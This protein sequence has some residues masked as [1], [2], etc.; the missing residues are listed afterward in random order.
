[1][2][3]AEERRR[4]LVVD[5]DPLVR[6]T[7]ARCLRDDC[8]V[9]TVPSGETAIKAFEDDNF[10]VV[11]LDLRMEGISGLETLRLLKER[12]PAPSVIILTAHE[13]M[14]TAISA[15]NLGAFNYLTKP[16]DRNHLR[17]VVRQGFEAYGRQSI[18]EEEMR[19]KLVG[20]HDSF[21][22]ILCHEFNTPLNGIIGFSEL[23]SEALAD[24]EHA[25]WAKEIGTAGDRLH[26]LLMEM[27]DYISVSHLA[28]SGVQN[29]FVPKDLLQPLKRI[30]ESKNVRLEIFQEDPVSLRGPS[31]AVFILVRQLAKMVAR[32]ASG[33]QV[34]IRTRDVS[35]DASEMLI[36]V[37]AIDGFPGE[38]HKLGVEDL[39]R[40]YYVDP[41]N[42]LPDIEVELAAFRKIAQYAGGKLET[43]RDSKGRVD[44]WVSVPVRI[45]TVAK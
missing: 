20:V 31:R 40:P 3:I 10:P 15:V 42:E 11:V 38:K 23:L 5:D 33:V 32:V 16:F 44:F 24:P 21:F 13:S 39:F 26:E 1:M 2:M 36:E 14:E 4:L 27:V 35:F 30:F 8:D 28:T 12:Q 25:A 17:N 34:T 7:L 45:S 43:R 22:S 9:T 37:R 18:R 19:E 29:D 6:Q 41:I